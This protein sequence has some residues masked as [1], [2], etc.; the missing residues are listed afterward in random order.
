MI[1]SVLS[2]CLY[3]ALLCLYLD[4]IKKFLKDSAV[5]RICA[6]AGFFV[7]IPVFLTDIVLYTIL[8]FPSTPAITTSIV[9]SVGM[10]LCGCAMLH[11]IVV[12][13]RVNQFNSIK[14]ILQ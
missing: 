4:R 10:V 7:S 11:N 8:H 13:H 2:H 5:T 12:W 3:L 14:L 1:T 9:T 6:V